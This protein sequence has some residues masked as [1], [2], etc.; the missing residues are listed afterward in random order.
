MNCS[1]VRTAA[2]AAVI[3]NLIALPASAATW[4][5]VSQDGWRWVDTASC[6]VKGGL[7]YC[8][9]AG[10]KK[11]NIAPDVSGTL[12]GNA[13][14]INVAVDCATGEMGDRQTTNFDAW[15]AS[16]YTVPKQYEWRKG[17]RDETESREIVRVVCGR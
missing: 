12:M 9:G 7:T 1:L 2:F 11:K 13:P 14:E 8:A 5:V 10:S 17:V 4:V 3:A 16:N 6:D 15:V